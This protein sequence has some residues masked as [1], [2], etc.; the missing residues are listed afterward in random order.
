MSQNIE[1]SVEN[2]EG[3]QQE[4]LWRSVLMDYPYFGGSAALQNAFVRAKQ[5][6]GFARGTLAK[7]ALIENYISR[8]ILVGFTPEL[9]WAVNKGIKEA[10]SHARLLCKDPED[11]LRL[12][13]RMH[14]LGVCAPNPNA[15]QIYLAVERFDEET[16]QPIG[17]ERKRPDYIVQL[18]PEAWID[19]PC[20]LQFA[21]PSTALQQ[22]IYGSP[23]EVTLY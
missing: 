16:G 22:F 4:R 12:E 1:Y 11:L 15:G 6:E 17:T 13:E 23:E 5:A 18:L 19:F 9:Y 2:P 10:S 8:W 3:S 14:W 20:R 7:G 21:R